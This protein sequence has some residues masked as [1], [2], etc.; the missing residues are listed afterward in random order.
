M[1][2]LNYFH[3]FKLSDF[4]T[5]VLLAISLIFLSACMHKVK[6]NNMET[7]KRVLMI[8]SPIDFRDEE[9][10]EP[11]AVFEQAGFEVKTASIQGKTARSVAQKEI[12]L[13]LTA[14]DVKTEDFD[15]IVFVGGAGMALITGDDSL[16]IL[17]VK[18]FNAGK[19][20]S[21][22]CVAPEILAKAGLLKGKRATVWEGSKN[23]LT[24]SGA[25]YTGESV[26][27]DGL[28]ITGNGPEAAKAF[29]ER[30]R[31]ELINL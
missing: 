12:G 5:L 23:I 1:R 25:Q 29:G 13:D 26:T 9:Y 27:Q 24:D 6:S 14:S 17:A 4:R 8:V 21:A 18:F 31:D 20:T 15:A 28:I 11:K 22:I 16:Q 2:C 3:T 19:I 10:F 7:T 30:V